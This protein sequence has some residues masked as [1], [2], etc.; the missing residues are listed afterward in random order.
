MPP[1]FLTKLVWQ[2]CLLLVVPAVV[3]ADDAAAEPKEHGNVAPY[4][5]TPYSVA[6]AMLEAGELKPGETH[7]DLGSGD[8]RLVI[9]AARD[10]GARSVG[11]ELEEKL[12]L[13]SRDQIEELNLGHLARIEQRDLFKADF[14]EADLVTVY[15]LPRALELL[16]PI[17]KEKMKPGSRVVSHDF[18]IPG[19]K[20]AKALEF[21]RDTEIEGF[22]HTI[23]VYP[24]DSNR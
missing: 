16:G 15:L 2:F 12:V 6:V 8:G 22:P 20:P 21:D 7:F 10:F 13:S 5:P 23:Y 11:Y 14:D 3:L 19:W 1:P 18:A 4:Y 9:L 17:L 24:I